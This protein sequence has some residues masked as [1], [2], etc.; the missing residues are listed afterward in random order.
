MV[1]SLLPLMVIASH[2][3]GMTWDEDD[4]HE[5]GRVILEYVEGKRPRE[6]AHFGTMYPGLFDVIPAWLEGRSSADRY[7]LRH[8]VN[9]VFGWIGIVFAGLL[10]GRLFGPWS[11]ILAAVLL[12]ASPRYFAHSMNNPK[13]LPFAA[14]SVVVLYCL[15]RLIPRWPYVTVSAG[16]AIA[17]GLALALGTRP[18]G[19]LYFGYLPLL[20]LT[21]VVG[22]RIRTAGGLRGID[23]RIHWSAAAQLT[24]RVGVVLVAGL[25][26]GTIFWPWAQASPLTRPFEA[27]TRA[28][29]YDFDGP[30]VF[31]GLDLPASQLPWSYLPTWLLIATPPV[32]L[33]GMV[34]SIVAPVRGWGWSRL[35]LWSVALFPL[36]LIVVR[37]STVYDG[38]RHVLFVYPP[39]VVLAASGWTAVLTSRFQWLR[40]GAVAL[41]IPGMA[42]LLAFHVR[43]SPNQVAYVNE[44]VGGPR[45]ALGRYELDYW[46]NCMLQAV[47]WS[48]NAASRAGM[49]VIVWGQ[50][51]HIIAYDAARFPQVIVAPSRT[52]PHHLE[53][54]MARG[55]VRDMRRLAARGDAVHRVT[56]GDGA[57]LCAV[58]PGPDFEELRLRLPAVSRPSS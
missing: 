28:S 16:A 26:L 23:R 40:A 53:L 34:L 30:V 17:A 57:V 50:P 22:Q 41:L 52:D 32:V 1:V 15:S 25:I 38:M 36:V 45:G 4:R 20:V 46:G 48:A 8:R 39:L 12:T 24:T 13:D 37:D 5:N 56:T 47:A 44:L 29:A 14:M 58:Y 33:A 51:P 9:A 18:G 7:V 2:D 49:P 10:A 42:T 3:F 31:D 6:Q 43:S 55:H 19:L 11:A 54:R 35:A 27:L 21:L